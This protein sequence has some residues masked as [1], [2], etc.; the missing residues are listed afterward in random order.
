MRIRPATV[1][2]VPAVCAI[3]AAFRP[4]EPLD[5]EVERYHWAAVE[6]SMVTERW[7]LE[8]PDGPAGY[9]I[10]SHPAWA[11]A[12]E[13]NCIAFIGWRPRDSEQLRGLVEFVEQRAREQGGKRLSVYC[14]EDEMAIIAILIAREFKLDTLARAWELDLRR[15][16]ERLLDLTTASREAMTR[17]GIRLLP[18]GDHAA[19]DPVRSLYEAWS[20]SRLDAPRSHEMMPVPFEQF[21]VWTRAPDQRPDRQWLAL[22]GDRVVGLSNL[23]YPPVRGNVWTNFT[24]TVRSHR[25]RG[26]ARA[27]KMETLAQAIELGVASVRTDNDE[28][29][30]PMLHINEEVGYTPIPGW[31]DYEKDL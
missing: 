5:P 20:D 9:G 2:D 10:L 16:R 27:V 22:D 31:A 18:L 26:I 11:L 24:G 17:Q 6:P 25:G 12:Q 30:A 29:N 13:R 8:A 23:R 3:D 7:I 4:D 1:E 19:A 21:L 15:H 28:R 14:R